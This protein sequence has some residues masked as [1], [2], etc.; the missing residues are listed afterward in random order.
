M[1]ATSVYPA[2]FVTLN[3]VPVNVGTWLLVCRNN[4]HLHGMPLDFFLFCLYNNNNN[5]NK[6]FIYL[7][8][9]LDI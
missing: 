5:N 9:F 1:D 8:Y 3:M 7:F 2:T 6:D 4:D